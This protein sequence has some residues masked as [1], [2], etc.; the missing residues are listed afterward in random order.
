MGVVQDL[1]AP[2]FK[3]VYLICREPHKAPFTWDVGQQEFLWNLLKAGK[4][5]EIVE[6]VRCVPCQMKRRANRTN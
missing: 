6:P 2:N 4:I 5:S 3:D 1:T